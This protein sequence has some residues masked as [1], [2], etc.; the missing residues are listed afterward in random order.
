MATSPN[1]AIAGQRVTAAFLNTNIPGPWQA[2]TLLNG[3]SNLGS[4]A[5]NAQVRQRDSVTLELIGVITGGTT[6]NGTQL[7]L[8]PSGLWPISRQNLVGQV[9][10][11]TGV[12]DAFTLYCTVGDG[13]VWL[14]NIPSGATQLSF[15]VFLSLD[16]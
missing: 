9:T 13:K 6:T 7:C 14:Y 4:G 3:W 5:A 15:H 10:N 11:G 1:T 12:G 2:V 16:A 8:L